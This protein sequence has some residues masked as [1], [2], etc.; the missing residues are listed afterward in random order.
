MEFW[1]LPG[2]AAFARTLA[3]AVRDG[4]NV[5]VAS[6]LSVSASVARMIDVHDGWGLGGTWPCVATGG[7]PIDDLYDALGLD[8]CIPGNRTIASLIASIGRSRRIIVSDV[9]LN[10]L[11]AWTDFATEYE[12]A[13][14]AVSKFDRTQLVIV[15]SGIPRHLLPRP[16]P[17]L[18]V[19]VWDG[20]VG[21]ADVMSYIA[22]AWRDDRRPVNALSRLSARIIVRLALWDFDLV[23]R[24]L[25]WSPADLLAPEVALESMAH[26]NDIV[27]G[28]SWEEGGL[29]LFDGEEIVHSLVLAGGGDAQ[30]E[31]SMRVWAAQAAELLPMLEIRRRRLV[32]RMKNVPDPPAR[33]ILDGS[34]VTDL[35]DVELGGLTHLARVH[36][37]PLVITQEA[38]RLRWLRNRLAH[39]CTVSL[40]EAQ[41]LFD[42]PR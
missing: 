32:D 25:D 19:L 9:N 21:E 29:C 42:L 26:E 37:Y 33:M 6:P 2:P 15:L 10:I 31:L 38:E 18:E 3:D 17:A 16:A 13:S 34:I 41:V 8:E 24:M 23:D 12:S 36:R 1:Q 5:I 20:W 4:G 14:R 7:L 22:S 40:D 11:K 35:D 39:Q 27:L 28:R 30:G